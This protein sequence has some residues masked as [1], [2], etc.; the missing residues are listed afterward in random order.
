[1]RPEG[2]G[3]LIKIFHLI[4]S[5][6]RDLP[7]CNIALNK[8]NL[9]NRIDKNHAPNMSKEAPFLQGAN[10]TLSKPRIQLLHFGQ[11]SIILLLLKT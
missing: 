10:I 1:V 3:K 8:L 11:L 6:N 4:G 2:L 7:V 9:I 5:R